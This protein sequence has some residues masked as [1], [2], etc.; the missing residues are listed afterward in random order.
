MTSEI[1]D[2]AYGILN[3]VHTLYRRNG[4]LLADN[5]FMLVR[6]VQALFCISIMLV[7]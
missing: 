5:H 6:L 1:D 7:E 2:R 4:V 3:R